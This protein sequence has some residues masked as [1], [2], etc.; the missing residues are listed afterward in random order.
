MRL[1]L[2]VAILLPAAIL[3]LLLLRI[4]HASRHSKLVVKSTPIIGAAG[5]A[6]TDINNDGLVLIDGEVWRATSSGPIKRGEPVRV[7][8]TEDVLLRVER[9]ETTKTQRQKDF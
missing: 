7:V 1:L 5:V 9:E 6:E 8:G 4:I 2:L 3:L